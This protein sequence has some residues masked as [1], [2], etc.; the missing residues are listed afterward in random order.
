V[1]PNLDL[2]V[3]EPER[4][5]ASLL[6]GCWRDLLYVPGPGFTS[7]LDPGSFRSN[8]VIVAESGQAVRISSFVVPAFGEELCRIRLEPLVSYRP[9]A[10]GS[11]FEPGRRGIVY[12]MA[13][14][15][16]SGGP[17]PADR[18]GWR[19]A[20]PSL[21]SRLGRVTQVRMLR[22]RVAGT[23]ATG[24]FGWLADRGL[25]ITGS[26]GGEVLL[27]AIPDES[28]QAALITSIGLYRALLDP[29]APTMPGA[30]REELLGYADRSGIEVK[31]ELR[32]LTGRA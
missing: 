11:F 2:P 28:E 8:F 10:L 29:N 3:P 13:S 12:A 27:L 18:P 7:P 19:Y 17:R 32:A 1:S 22:E 26:D 14:D 9:E 20:G 24:S 15:R 5:R 21:T 4:R 16:R 25:A 31:V 23:D 30:S 6:L